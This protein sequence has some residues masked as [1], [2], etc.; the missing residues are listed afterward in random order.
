MVIRVIFILAFIFSSDS[1]AVKDTTTPIPSK[2]GVIYY[3]GNESGLYQIWASSPDGLNQ[4]PIT[5]KGLTGVDRA[6]HPA[7]SPDGKRISFS[8]YVG[9]RGDVYVANSDGTNP[10]KLTNSQDG[11]NQVIPNFS[12]DGQSIAFE[13]NLEEPSKTNYRLWVIRAD[14]AGLHELPIE[15]SS[16]GDAYDDMGPKFSPDGTKI[17]FASDRDNQPGHFDLYVVDVDGSHLRRLTYG[18]NNSF[19][20]GWS[21]D[22]RHIVFNAQVQ[23]DDSNPGYGELRI[24]KADGQQQR[25]LTNYRRS[26]RLLPFAASPA[27]PILRG[28]V[29]PSWSPNG[30]NVAF[31]RQSEKTS[32]FEIYTINLGTNRPKRLKRLTNS[33]PGVNHVSLD[34]GTAP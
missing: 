1:Y 25:R 32:Q 23:L 4:R 7:I 16:S 29:T 12:P 8:G 27:G 31:C 19:S 13:S 6:S 10:I 33:S 18:V 14:G 28:D 22:G 21:P 20:R 9:S 3:T 15:K 30:K 24:M 17:L 5:S 2:N 11:E 34:W 26:L